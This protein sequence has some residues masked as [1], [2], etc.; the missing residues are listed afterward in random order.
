MKTQ[1]L[2]P[3]C[4][5]SK[6]VFGCTAFETM[7]SSFIG[8][9]AMADDSPRTFQTPS[10]SPVRGRS[11]PG[12]IPTNKQSMSAERDITL[13][14]HKI[15]DHDAGDD[16]S[17]RF[18]W[19]RMT[20]LNKGNHGWY[21]SRDARNFGLTVI[22]R[23]SKGNEIALN[24]KGKDLQPDALSSKPRRAVDLQPGKG[25]VFDLPVGDFAALR[26]GETYR[27]KIRWT[28]HMHPSAADRESMLAP[29]SLRQLGISP[30]FTSD[31]IR[32][33]LAGERHAK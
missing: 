30:T 12:R 24:S 10:V 5:F 19:I 3:R 6:F 29:K 18:P 8:A 16:A 7:L 1:R 4:F 22:I 9:V 17:E 31:E 21:F 20:L 14:I 27:I 33:E 32:V 2:F 15:P 26:R 28:I 11:L 25:E 13:S 23:D